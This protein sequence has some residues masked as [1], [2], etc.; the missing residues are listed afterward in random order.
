MT[1]DPRQEDPL[2]DARLFEEFYGGQP[3]AILWFSP[4][5]SDD[6]QQ[7]VDFAFT[8]ANTEGLEYLK[9]TPAQFKN[10]TIRNSPTLS[11]ELR[12]QVLDEMKWVYE[13][14]KKA[15]SS[16]FNAA[17]NK[18]ARV[19]RSK[20]RGGIL[21]VVQDFTRE[22]KM[23]ATLQ[24]QKSSL[25]Q[26]ARQ[27]EQ[28]KTLLDNILKNTSNGIC[29]TRAIRNDDG[30]VIDAV[31]IIAND[32][33]VHA[34][35]VPREFFINKRVTEIQPGIV[36]TEY[37]QGS[38]MTLETGNPFIWQHMIEPT[39]RWIESTVSRL[40]LNHL[41]H[42]F[43]DITPLKQVQ[44]QIEQSASTLKSVFDA[45][46]T[47]MALL[48]PVYNENN[49]IIDFRFVLVNATISNLVHQPPALLTGDL[50]GNWFPGYLA[51][52]AFK[53][54]RDT[55]LT[56]QR[57]RRELHYDADGLD[58]YLDIQCIKL[59]NQLLVCLS[60]H[61]FLRKSQLKLEQTIA[62]LEQS[63]RY[64]EDFA[65]AA[66]HDMREPL[67][68]ILLF[69][70]QLKSSVSS[71]IDP[72]DLRIL[73]RIESAARHLNDFVRDLLSFSYISQQRLVKH[74]ID[75]NEIMQAV[76]DELE[77]SIAEKHAVITVEPLP[78]VE[79]NAR[80]F[81]QLFQN[82]IGNALKYSS[83]N[84]QPVITI[85]SQLADAALVAA[86]LPR[87][88]KEQP[89]YIIE[90]IDNG[91][92]F[93]QQYAEQIFDMFERLHTKS[94]YAGTGIGLAIARKVV[95]NHQGAIWA[96]SEPGKGATF[97]VLLPVVH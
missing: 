41:I 4:I 31:V 92:G 34:T 53:M 30:I 94:Q 50:A 12:N 64:L 81:E 38:A 20:L 18:H 97:F 86:R 43:T 58:R 42:I 14:G 73:N 82:L 15:T 32:A 89:H 79:G 5:W 6:G 61:S 40:D 72:E 37:F 84:A 26:G 39:G 62:S 55:Y 83:L 80:Q 7:I 46:Q 51:T 10:L 44:L 66:S 87:N 93:S 74:T 71:T 49:E 63:N 24:A 90:V 25:E 21:T 27:L 78:F 91:I 22:K 52:D 57:Q 16:I 19:M 28:Q 68:K 69:V 8:Y 96:E 70:D 76:L 29:V 11:A 3:Q 48:D 59:N 23:I 85:R 2:F 45:A 13:T 67:R 47:G 35:G 17:L 9:L 60:D 56:G 33:A 54:Y 75:L 65:H 36:E 77:L 88:P 95:E 1:T